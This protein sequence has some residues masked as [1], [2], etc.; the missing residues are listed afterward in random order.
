MTGVNNNSNFQ[1]EQPKGNLFGAAARFG[2]TNAT[3]KVEG[4]DANTKGAQEQT[5]NIRSNEA[6]SGNSGTGVTNAAGMLLA[7][8]FN[9]VGKGNFISLKGGK[10]DGA[11]ST[12]KPELKVIEGGA[13]P[14][15]PKEKAA[16]MLDMMFGNS[17]ES[18]AKFEAESE[19]ANAV[20]PEG[21]VDNANN[22]PKVDKAGTQVLALNDSNTLARIANAINKAPDGDVYNF[23]ASKSLINFFSLILLKKYLPTYRAG[24]YLLG[25]YHLRIFTVCKFYFLF[26]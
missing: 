4:T 24:I 20:F 26:K 22:L 18:L 3:G 16:D 10:T 6:A 5:K 8:N 13:K 1:P 2:K 11:K 7:G 17:A 15:S 25:R 12:D 14:S 23:I 19:R 21:N 9:P